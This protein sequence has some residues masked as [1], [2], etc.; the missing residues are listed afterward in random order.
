MYLTLRGRKES[1]TTSSISSL[2]FWHLALQTPAPCQ[3]L[4]LQWETLCTDFSGNVCI[5]AKLLQSCLIL[6]NP[7]TV[8]CQA[9]LS[10][11]FSKQEYWSGFPFSSPGD[12]LNPG[13]EP[14]SL[15]SPALAGKF[16]TTSAVWEAQQVTNQWAKVGAP[17]NMYTTSFSVSSERISVFRELSGL[18]RSL[19]GQ[20]HTWKTL[21]SNRW[22][23]WVMLWGLC[24]GWKVDC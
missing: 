10:M 14:T 3:L 11:G 4:V 16:F 8:A 1:G 22:Q 18:S 15:I 19:H 7:R 12:L 9:P 13:I 23:N 6:C 20:A 5:R 17:P 2:S 24:S 21:S